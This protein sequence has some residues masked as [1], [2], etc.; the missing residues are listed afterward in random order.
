M[1]AFHAYAWC[2]M[3]WRNI[4]ACAVPLWLAGNSVLKTCCLMTQ[5]RLFPVMRLHTLCVLRKFGMCPSVLQL[6]RTTK[7]F[8]VQFGVAVIFSISTTRLRTLRPKMLLGLYVRTDAT[9][10]NSMYGMPLRTHMRDYTVDMSVNASE[11]LTPDDK[12]KK[13]MW[14]VPLLC[15]QWLLFKFA[16][17]SPA[18]ELSSLGLED[19]E[20]WC[21]E[22][23][24]ILLPTRLKAFLKIPKYTRI[25]PY[26]YGTVK[27]KCF[28]AGQTVGHICT[29]PAHSC[30]RKVVSFCKWPFRRRW[31]FIHRAWE[32]VV[33]SMGHWWSLV[34]QRRLPCHVFP[35]AC[36][37]RE[38]WL[39]QRVRDAAWKETYFRCLDGRC[40]S[41]LWSSSP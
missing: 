9:W 35:Y 23:F 31:R 28:T 15:Y 32:T 34:T 5:M 24:R 13:F 29:K 33:R 39:L 22:V 36:C 18:W 8:A 40:R 37:R 25:V 17:L 21:Q 6:P 19:A 1:A 11:V 16:I 7:L 10:K 14:K 30:L 3:V 26:Y 2:H 12:D 41:V 20:A 27:S 38:R 4:E